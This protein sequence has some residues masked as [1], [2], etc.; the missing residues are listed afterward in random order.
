[1]F[2]QSKKTT[3]TRMRKLHSVHSLLIGREFIGEIEAGKTRYSFTYSPAA[4]AISNG[5]LEL[6][7]RFTVKPPGGPSRKSDN[8]KATLL[9][10]QSG[11][12]T[13]PQA[14]RGIEATLLGKIPTDGLPAT[15]ATG[16]RGY[17]GVM[18]F[19]LSPLDGRTL[20]LPFE[21]SAVQLN[22]RLNPSDP[23]AGTLQFWYSVAVRALYDPMPDDALTL[24]SVTEINQILKA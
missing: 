9:A 4:A 23:L 14:P 10:T 21:V 6:S 20:G 1:M 12:T 13:A 11:L 24:Q 3:S 15:D 5:K 17:V 19:R 18:Y 7:G 8:V 22:G 2:T 16:G